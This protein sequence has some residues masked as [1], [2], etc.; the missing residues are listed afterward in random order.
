[1]KKIKDHF[2]GH[3]QLYAQ[4]RPHYPD[5]LYTYLFNQVSQQKKAWDCGTGNGQI[6][7]RLA[8]KFTRVYAT[9]ISEKQIAHA[10]KRDNIEYAIVRA[11]KT[12]FEDNTFDLVTVGQA[13]HWFDFSAFFQEVKRT[14]RNEA[15]IA[16]WGYK[17][18]EISAEIDPIIYDFYTNV[19]GPYWDQERRHIDEEYQNIAF[20]FEEIKAPRFTIEVK[21]SMA[22]LEGFLNTWSS[23]QKYIKRNGENP[24]PGCVEKIRSVVPTDALEVKFPVFMR[25]GR[26]RK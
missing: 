4:F 13:L 14:S 19:T 11:E 17:L 25:V 24:V 23:V 3:S 7:S 12:N 21:W 1:M 15:V 2:S 5:D 20:P 16:V 26:V 9:D 18:L 10:V 22:E 6:A 8:E